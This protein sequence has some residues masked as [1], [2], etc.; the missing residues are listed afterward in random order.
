MKRLIPILLIAVFLF[1]CKKENKS[2]CTNV[3][4]T[5]VGTPCQQW[6][7]KVN[8]QTYPSRNIPQ[9]YQQDGLQVCAVFTLYEDLALCPC[10]G[11]KFADIQ[12]MQ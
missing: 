4:I 1:S 11:G 7:I 12:A 2:A 6:G 9:S 10:C 8:G 3:I 5:N